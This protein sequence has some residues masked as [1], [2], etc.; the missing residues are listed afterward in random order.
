MSSPIADKKPQLIFYVDEEGDDFTFYVK[1]DGTIAAELKRLSPPEKSDRRDRRE[2]ERFSFAERIYIKNLNLTED[3]LKILES[4]WANLKAAVPNSSYA[5]LATQIQ[6]SNAITS[7]Q[8][9][10]AGTHQPQDLKELESAILEILREAVVGP[11]LENEPWAK[12]SSPTGSQNVA[13]KRFEDLDDDFLNKLKDPALKIR[14]HNRFILRKAF[15]DLIRAKQ[16]G[17]GLICSSYIG[18]Y[19]SITFRKISD[20]Q[21][22]G[23]GDYTDKQHKRKS[24]LFSL[25]EYCT[26]LFREVFERTGSDGHAQGLLVI[27]GATKSAKSEITRG[28]IQRYLD[29]KAPKNRRHHLVTFEDPIERFYALQDLRSPF[30]WAAVPFATRDQKRD[31]TPREKPSDAMLL[32]EALSD[33]LRQT[34]RVFFVGETRDKAEWKVLLDFAATGHLIVTTAHAG[35]LVE[36]MHTIFEALAVKTPADRSE[37]A[38]KLLGVI[39]IRLCDDLTFKKPVNNETEAPADPTNILF[40]ALWRRS[41]RGIASLTSDGLASLLPHRPGKHADASEDH[42]DEPSCL[43]RRSLIEQIFSDS[44]E[45]L[46]SFFNNDQNALSSFK[47]EA[48]AK[49]IEWDLQGV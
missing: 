41:P 17:R 18:D 36:A 15:P 28:I 39:N 20:D 37:I 3:G 35:S 19:L 43:G 11:S 48:Y 21:G 47:T 6:A 42:S 14:W 23:A 7:F 29:A 26:L 25:S 8:T 30:P 9:L 44:N 31:Y 33:A 10:I 16:T 40:P 24:N 1:D 46:L 2:K 5:Y 27:T 13:Q 34:P 49:S 32:A 12:Q 45:D 38:S 4:F 22:Y